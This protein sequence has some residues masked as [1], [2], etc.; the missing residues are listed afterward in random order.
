MPTARLF[1]TTP[2][3]PFAHLFSLRARKVPLRS[4]RQA[5]SILGP[6]DH[7]R[8][9]MIYVFDLFDR[10]ARPIGVG[11]LGQPLI[12]CHTCH[13]MPPILVAFTV[14]PGTHYREA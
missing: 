5:V 1:G 6:P 12:T 7:C 11:K 13:T 14:F 8:A 2:R 3:V 9:G 10:H 4:V